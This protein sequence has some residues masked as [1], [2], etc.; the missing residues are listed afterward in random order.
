MTTGLKTY[1]NKLSKSNLEGRIDIFRDMSD[2]KN[3]RILKMS[4]K[5]TW[6]NKIKQ[7]Q[8][9]RRAL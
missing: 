8:R 5:T 1:M 4:K 2:K 3:Q 9:S 7:N 6:Y